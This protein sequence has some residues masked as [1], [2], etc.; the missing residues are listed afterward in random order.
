MVSTSSFTDAD[1]RPDYIYRAIR[2][3]AYVRTS[4]PFPRSFQPYAHLQTPE[5]YV[6]LLRERFTYSDVPS[7]SRAAGVQ[8]LQ[9]VSWWSIPGSGIA[10]GIV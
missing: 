3:V 4:A 1:G 2:G 5:G 7:T 8:E 9:P 6:I 10:N